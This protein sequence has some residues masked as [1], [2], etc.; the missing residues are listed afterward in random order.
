MHARS[1]ILELDSISGFTNQNSILIFKHYYCR[2]LLEKYN[3]KKLFQMIRNYF[4]KQLKVNSKSLLR[5]N[6]KMWNNI[7]LKKAAT[8]TNHEGHTFLLDVFY[9]NILRKFEN[10]QRHSAISSAYI[11]KGNILVTKIILQSFYT[12]NT[13]LL[14]VHVQLV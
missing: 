12:W 10:F 14:C 8:A 13:F 2:I 7:W 11:R 5:E 4:R 6:L 1:K 3:E 9:W